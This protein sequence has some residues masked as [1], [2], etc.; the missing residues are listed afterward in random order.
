MVSRQCGVCPVWCSR[1]FVEDGTVFSYLAQHLGEFY[2]GFFR[3]RA[4]YAVAFVEGADGGPLLPITQPP[5]VTPILQTPPIQPITPI[6]PLAPLGTLSWSGLT[7][8]DFLGAVR[9]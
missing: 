9:G 7:W 4:G 1:S 5:P 3:D 8:D 2:D 6:P